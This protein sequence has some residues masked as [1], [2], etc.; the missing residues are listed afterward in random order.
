MHENLENIILFINKPQPLSEA[1]KDYIIRSIKETDY[2]LT[3]TAAALNGIEEEKRI[4]AALL[5]ATVEELEAKS[6]IIALQ[7]AELEIEGALER[8]RQEAINMSKPADV[9][10]ICK[11]VYTELKSLG[12]IEMRNAMINIHDDER[13]NFVNYDYSDS[14]GEGIHYL[15]NDIQLP[16]V[17]SIKEDGFLATAISSNEPIDWKTFRQKIAEETSPGI[18]NVEDLQYYLYSIGKG[19]IGI[20]TYST[21]SKE[22]QEL[23]KRFRNVFSF[24]YRR[25]LDVSMAEAQAREAQVELALERVRA[26]TMAMQ[27]SNEFNDTIWL[28]FEQFRELVDMHDQ[29]TIG[30][31]NE[32][33]QRVQF[34]ISMQDKQPESN[35]NEIAAQTEFNHKLYYGTKALSD[36]ELK[37]YLTYSSCGNDSTKNTENIF[38]DARGFIHAA[39]FSKG[40]ISFSAPDARPVESIRLLEK[41]TSVFDLTHTRLLDLQKAEAQARETQI[42]AALE[43]TR[44]QSMVMQ[45]SNELDTTLRVFHE[46]ILSLGIESA[47]SF[48]WLPDEEKQQHIFWAAWAENILPELS[49]NN[50]ADVFNSKAINYQLNRNDAATAQCL[51]DWK[52]NEPVVSYYVPPNGVDNYFAAW[53]ELIE[54]VEHLNPVYF[55]GGLYYVE[56]FMKY[57][58]FGVMVK[59]ELPDEDKK[60]LSRFS[61]EFER[62][63]TRFLDLQNAE[64]SARE[65]QIELAL[66]RVRARTMAMH[67]SDEV[68]EVAHTLYAELQKLDFSYGASTII[69]MNKDNGDMEHWVGGFEQGKYPE[70]YFVKYFDNPCY[71]AQLNAWKEGEKFLTYELKG[72]E[73]EQYDEVMFTKTDYRFFPEKEKNWM[74]QVNSVTF[75][76]AYLKHGAIHWGPTPL[77]G[78]QTKILRRFATVFEQTY[79]RFLDLQKA[80]AQAREALIEA[81]LEKVRSTSLAIHQSQELEKVVVVLF[82]KLKELDVPFDSAFIYFFD[83]PQ[84]NIKAWV[85]TKKLADPLKVYMPYEEEMANNPIIVDLWYAFE[86][87]EDGLNKSYKGKEKDDYYRYEARHNK[88]V[89]PEDITNFCIQAQSWTTSFATEKNSIMGFDSWSGH[90]IKEDEFKILKRFA[91][92]FEQAYVRF[93]DLQK[94]EAQA[95]EG[96]IEAA[97]EKI[98]S[99]SLAMHHSNEL[100]D[101]IAVFFEK[102]NELKV[103]LGTVGITLFDNKSKD[104][105]CWVGNSIQEPQLVFVP[106]SDDNKL[107][108]TFLKDTWVGM[109]EKKELINKLYTRQQKD[110]YFEH[111][112]FN[113]DLTTIPESAREVIRNMNSEICCFFPYHNFGLF[114]DSWNGSHYT[115][116]DISVLRRAGKVFEQAYIRFLDIQKSE[117][118]AREAQIETALERVRSIAMSMMKTDDLATIC[119]AVYKQLT[120]LGFGDIRAAQ[121]YIR[122]D[123]QENFINYD[124]GEITGADVVTVKYNS[125]PN[126]KRIYDVIKT[127]GEALVH[128]VISQE[129]LAAW[130]NYLYNT[131]HQPPENNLDNAAEL[132]YYLYSFGIGAFGIS[133]FRKISAD[134]LE[135]LKRFR[136]VFSLSYKRYYDIALAEAQA[137]EAKVEA[138]LEKVRS[139]T[140]AMHTSNELAETAAEV[141]KQLIGLGIEPNRL[142]IGI[143]KDEQGDIEFWVTGEDGSKISTQFTGNANRN[144]SMK[145]MLNAWMEQKKSL[146]IEMHGDEL[147]AYLYYLGQELHVPFKEGLSQ[148]TRWQHIGFFSNGFIG[149]AS[150]DEQPESTIQLLERFAGVFNLTFTRFNDLK[151]AEAQ[152]LQ[153]EL[154]LMEIKAARKKAEDTL[155]ELKSTQAQLIQSEKMA[156]LGELTAGIAHEIQNP[157]NFVNN[158]SDLSRELIDEMNEELEKGDLEEAKFIAADIKQNLDK[159]Y[160]HGKRAESIVTGMLQHSHSSSG[161]KEPTDINK[162]ADEYLRL[163]YHGLRAKDKLFNADIITDF[164]ASIGK[165]NIV[166]QDIARVILNL[167]NN[168]FYAVNEKQK[169]LTPSRNEFGTGSEGGI[170]KPT[171]AVTTKSDGGHVTISVT[172]NGNG[173]PQKIKD[174]IFQPFFTTKPTGQGTGLGLSLSYDIVKAHGGE[175]KVESKELEGATFIIQLPTA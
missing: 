154:D 96:Q 158:F 31:I 138:S 89:I 77:T 18:E 84:K 74:R 115:D 130:K 37:Q 151:L 21:I 72:I 119:E 100:K 59:T 78:E 99:R 20:S 1:E 156:S 128:N 75:S 36:A 17:K 157:L 94:A 143:I 5:Q 58:C 56:A 90:Q 125:H 16:G 10:A 81:A 44:T 146:T 14:T 101:V 102:L 85:A 91:K 160:H 7:K 121:I 52:G 66:E 165:I 135:I 46:Q 27:H 60:I 42:E 47:F 149:I 45:H 71:T 116:A 55:A 65:A 11:V 105:F 145:K 139:R 161:Q 153:S 70:S 107:D 113:N 32:A 40:F 147:N 19:S 141:F 129:E 43:R 114:A 3:V 174:K 48:L 39:F 13:N 163:S 127:A 64:N 108:D 106:F 28:L 73:K 159:I 22:K 33:E 35:E 131:L 26:A 87:G 118:Q 117:A 6:A 15:N 4:T 134:E 170:Y 67:K 132:H 68:K 95:R 109:T 155:S 166:A 133:T 120:L 54:G 61:I 92:V 97:L 69:I 53:Q 140:L 110:K 104:I 29:V 24:A 126:T 103:L 173:I 23:L 152:A 137:R 62:A 164:D 148:K 30:T 172:D 167:V 12:F 142:Y 80:E 76:L 82:K 2:E 83:K 9:P 25:Y 136:N 51:A 162:L 50:E 168:A 34:W 86:N 8:V 122:N 49:F 63:Y 124:Y 169:A 79:T 175:M 112:F 41:F 57:G 150:P 88:S 38:E 111:L 98:R 123:E 93:L 171:V 144:A